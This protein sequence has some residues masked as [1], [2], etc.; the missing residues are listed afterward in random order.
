MST[1]QWISYG[2]VDESS[3]GDHSVTFDP[4]MGPLVD[5]KLQPSGSHARCRVSSDCA[6]NGEG[7]YDPFVDGDEVLVALPEG[8][9]RAGAVILG[10]LNSQIDKF[11]S[12][13]A[14]Q[15]V[16]KNATAFRRT[17]GP[18][19]IETGDSLLLRTA[20]AGSF[21]LM[22]KAGNVTIADGFKNF[23][24]LGADFVGLQC[25]DDDGTVKSIVQLD[26]QDGSATVEVADS[27]KFTM[28]NDGTVTL[29]VATS[30]SIQAAGMAPS[31]HAT[32]IEAMAN[33]LSFVLMGLA[34]F[35]APGA[36]AA[37]AV[38]VTAQGIVA[39]AIGM[40]ATGNIALMQSAIA[41]ALMSKAPNPTGLMPGV[42]C[43]GVLLG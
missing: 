26:R 23:L 16:T 31:E 19:V 10:R 38:P 8:D 27:A 17:R 32:T 36:L 12:T 5:V 9:E 7:A 34:A 3:G 35:S 13:V 11:P 21:V 20:T 6:G 18:Y 42:A 25:A 39:A 40:A 1:R 28:Q 2:V 22:E 14:G 43:P 33:L 41:A 30:V 29:N 24:H 4:D 37:L 15:D